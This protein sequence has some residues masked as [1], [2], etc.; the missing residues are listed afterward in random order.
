M[1]SSAPTPTTTDAPISFI[2]LKVPLIDDIIVIFQ[3]SYEFKETQRDNP[4][5]VG[6][7]TNVELWNLLLDSVITS[8]KECIVIKKSLL[9]SRQ[10]QLSKRLENILSSFVAPY[11]IRN[12]FFG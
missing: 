9:A 5:V 7:I 2:G 3:H 6:D 11:A 12:R 10:K 1:S 8:V 4:L